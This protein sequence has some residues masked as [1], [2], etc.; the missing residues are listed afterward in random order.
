MTDGGTCELAHLGNVLGGEVRVIDVLL[1]LGHQ[2]IRDVILIEVLD[3]AWRRGRTHHGGE[4]TSKT[5]FRA[6]IGKSFPPTECVHVS[7]GCLSAAPPV[8]RW[9]HYAK[10]TRIV[11]RPTSSLS[12]FMLRVARLAFCCTI[13][14]RHTA[15]AWCDRQLSG[16]RFAAVVASG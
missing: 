13:A 2:R 12:A 7:L 4:S 8:E 10:D 11:V 14:S 9:I 1:E 16:H 5:F 15:R 3:L 6:A